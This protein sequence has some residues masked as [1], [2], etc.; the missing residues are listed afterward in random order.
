LGPDET[1]AH[2]KLRSRFYLKLA[3]HSHELWYLHWLIVGMT[4]W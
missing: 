2:F 4:T 3:S 1:F